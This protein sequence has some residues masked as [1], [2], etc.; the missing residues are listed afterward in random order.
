MTGI[1]VTPAAKTALLV[2]DVQAGTLAN[3]KT[4]PGDEL[5]DRIARLAD[6]FRRAGDPVL[7]VVSTGPPAGETTYGAGGR[8]W[9]EGFDTLD[10]RLG[11]TLEEPLR[12]RS[13][14]SAFAG[15]DIDADLRRRGV[16]EVVIVG[17]ATS[18]GVEST[19]RAAY[20]LGYSVRV[21]VDA[22]ADPS[23]SAHERFV[24]GILP[25]LGRAVSTDDLL[26]R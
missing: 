21:V 14:W 12:P 26:A 2:V 3:A 13:G 16:G 22:V 7:F 24:D 9:P 10:A 17:L 11:R 19:A 4:T 5:V 20:D 6:R 8:T 15:T 18:F 23:P 1:D 25:A